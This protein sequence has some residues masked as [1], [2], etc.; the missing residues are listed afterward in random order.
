MRTKVLLFGTDMKIAKLKSPWLGA[1]VTLSALLG[2]CGGG[3]SSTASVAETTVSGDVVKG[4][5]AKAK[6]SLYKTTT[7]G[8]QGDLLTQTTTDDKGHY[9]ATVSG[10]TGVVTVVASVV[11]GTTSMC[12]E[13]TGQTIAPKRPFCCVPM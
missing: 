10:Y 12:D 7:D 3:G 9:S 5:I 6:V 4:P 1:V 2:G 13:A 8:K 11:N